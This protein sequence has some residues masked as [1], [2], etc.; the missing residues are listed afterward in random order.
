MH[1]LLLRNIWRGLGETIASPVRLTRLQKK[2]P[3][4]RFYPGAYIDKL[5]VLGKYCVLF[6]NASI[7]N[8]VIGDHTFVQKD[9]LINNATAGKFCSVAMRVTI[10]PGQHPTAYVS[11]HPAFYSS[12]QPVAKT[13]SH[14]ESFSPFRRI[15]IGHDVWIGQEAVIM[16]GVRIGTGAVIAAS[17]VVTKDV[18][19]YA[20]VAGVPAR[21]VRYRF[22]EEVRGRLAETRWWDMSEEWLQEHCH[23]FLDPIKFLERWEEEEP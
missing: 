16:D 2:H 6:R 7:I 1:L 17:A 18:P 11:T 14:S 4:C 21:V 10:G 22:S 19:D 13:F 8:S 3:T 12:T 20:I 23:L 5:S 15:D 9:S